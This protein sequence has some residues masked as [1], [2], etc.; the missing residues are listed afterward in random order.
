MNKLKEIWLSGSRIF[1][2]IV[3]FTAGMSKLM[4]FPSLIGPVW[5]EERLEP[6][7]LGLFARFIA[8][9]QVLVGLLL[10]SRRFSTL[11]AVMLFP[12]LLCILMVTIS[13]NW[14]GTPL[15]NAFLLLLNISLLAA[16]YHKLKFIFTEDPTPLTK[17]SPLRTNPAMDKL[18]IGALVIFFA[19]LS[20]IFYTPAHKI[21]LWT[22]GITFI[23][24]GIT[25]AFYKLKIIKKKA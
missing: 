10:L 5:L 19:G 11:G 16:D 14:T 22:G 12:L 4:P 25:N 7:G 21:L 24:L 2:G 17:M 9:S 1:L 13:L 23:G 3:F 18:W 6:H 15:V 20:A 8:F